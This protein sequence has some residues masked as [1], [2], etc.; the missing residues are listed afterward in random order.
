MNRTFG[1]LKGFAERLFHTI[2]LEGKSVINESSPL[3]SVS[4]LLG[5]CV[6][7]PEELSKAVSAS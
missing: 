4:D 5:R 6:L 2:K 7:P 3:E 1:R